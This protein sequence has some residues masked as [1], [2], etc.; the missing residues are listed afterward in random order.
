MIVYTD[1]RTVPTCAC[2]YRR[3]REVDR[4]FTESREL[5]RQAT[6]VLD[7][8]IPE[9]CQAVEMLSRAGRMRNEALDE[10]RAALDAMEHHAPPVQAGRMETV[11]CQVEDRDGT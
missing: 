2:V 8:P 7:G 3:L 5:V 9:P 1:H 10:V 4:L 11:T 6:A